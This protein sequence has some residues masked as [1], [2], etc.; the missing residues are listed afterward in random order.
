[1]SDIVKI[2]DEVITTE[3][4]INLLKLSGR[5]EGA[6]EDILRDKLAAHAAQREGVEVSQE[7]VQEKSEEFRRA[8]GLHRAKDTIE[9]FDRLGVTLDEFEQFLTESLLKEKV[10]DK[11]SSDEAV[12]EY[13]RL[14]SP[15]FDSIDVSHIVVASDGAARE[16][17]SILEEDPDAFADMAKE[18]SIAETAANGGKIG[19]VMRG[20]LSGE[21]ESKLFNAKAGDIVG[22][23]ESKDGERFEI[24][25]IDSFDPATL[26]EETRAEIRR[27]LKEV[28]L[29]E[30][31]SEHQIEPL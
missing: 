20:S 10:L 14:N 6:M 23:F 26:D 12:E 25:K 19:K 2:D 27:G 24:F 31:A 28:W 21:V 4:F 22:P 7:E 5:F 8:M 17:M 18:N 16:L 30:R 9:Y 11:V 15:R 29:A 3:G 1:M 13:F